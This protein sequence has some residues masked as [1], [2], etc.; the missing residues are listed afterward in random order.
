MGEEKKIN[1][2]L[3][4]KKELRVTTRPTNQLYMVLRTHTSWAKYASSSEQHPGDKVFFRNNKKKI[5]KNK[6]KVWALG[7]G[8]CVCVRSFCDKYTI[9]L[10]FYIYFFLHGGCENIK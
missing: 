1:F 2:K 7:G 5:N 10:P 4:K 8:G 9:V 3:K 6:K